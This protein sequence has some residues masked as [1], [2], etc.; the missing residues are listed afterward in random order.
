MKRLLPLEAPEQTEA[1]EGIILE[2]DAQ[3]VFDTILSLYL[4]NTLASVLL[5]AK[6][7]EHTARMTAM[8]AASD[9]TEQMLEELRLELN[10]ARQNAITTEISEI[11]GGANA[12]ARSD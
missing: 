3:P 1:A 5:E 10:H 9:N 12:L 7:S 2:P 8:T 11:V 6:T 4:E